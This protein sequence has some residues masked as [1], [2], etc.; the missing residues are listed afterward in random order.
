MDTG[1]A[2]IMAI[3]VATT[4]AM[5]QDMPEADMIQEISIAEE[6]LTKTETCQE[7][8]EVG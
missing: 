5:Q 8:I 1:T 4:M 7:L 3:I 2:I 6:D